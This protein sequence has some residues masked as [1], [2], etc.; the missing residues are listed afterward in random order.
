MFAVEQRLAGEPAMGPATEPAE[1]RPVARAADVQ[2]MVRSL[3]EQLVSEANAVLREHGR[4]I[5]LTDHCEP[6][7]LAYSLD[8]GARHARID[9]TVTGRTAVSRLSF[10][11]EPAA[12][13]LCSESDVAALILSLI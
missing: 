11:H 7:T 9:M 5:D 13:R 8:C 12:P 3:A 1:P 2:V 4:A 6:G 10:G